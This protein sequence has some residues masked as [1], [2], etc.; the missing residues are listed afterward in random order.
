MRIIS[1]P[2]VVFAIAAFFCAEWLTEAA[3]RQQWPSRID[4]NDE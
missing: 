2:F 3:D 1:T 4:E